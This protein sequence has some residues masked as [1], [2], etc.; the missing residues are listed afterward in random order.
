MKNSI[1]I[2]L[3]KTL[4]LTNVLIR[5]VD[6]NKEEN[7]DSIALQ[8]ENY[9]K[10]K[11]ALPIGPIIQKTVHSMDD[12]GELN[13]QIYLM[14]QSNSFIHSV[15]SPF[16]MESIIRV[17]NCVYARYT[18]PD[19]SINLAYNKINVVAFEEGI[20]LSNE[21]YTIFVDRQ[22]DAIVADF[23]VERE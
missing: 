10:S 5:D 15:E 9:V 3:N 2:S 14:R 22:D 12:T 6:M 21:S 18:G 16:R 20:K 4:K 7:A 17:R 13:I 19:E 1:Q 11:G 8:M 23:F